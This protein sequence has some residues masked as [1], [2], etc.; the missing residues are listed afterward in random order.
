MDSIGTAPSLLSKGVLISEL[1]L[2]TKA[3]IGTVAN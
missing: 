3:S 1:V 2:Y